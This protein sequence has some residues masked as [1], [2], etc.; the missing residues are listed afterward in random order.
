MNALELRE[1]L[2]ELATREDL[3]NIISD[4]A[5][6]ECGWIALSTSD[7]YFPDIEETFMSYDVLENSFYEIL[8]GEDKA[9]NMYRDDEIMYNEEWNNY[10]DS[11]C[12]DGQ[13]SNYAYNNWTAPTFNN[14]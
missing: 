10:T 1:A 2:D 9:R 5:G 8:G 12:K 6:S 11:L 7:E 4:I 3:L 14:N 13:I